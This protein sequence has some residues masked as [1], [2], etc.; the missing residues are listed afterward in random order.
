[1]GKAKLLTVKERYAVGVKMIK[2][3]KELTGA[4]T[5]GSVQKATIT[6]EVNEPVTIELKMWL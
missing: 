3:I 5:L 6:T 2:L 4:K 1:M